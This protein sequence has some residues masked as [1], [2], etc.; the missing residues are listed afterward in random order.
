MSVVSGDGVYRESIFMVDL[1]HSCILVSRGRSMGQAMGTSPFRTV[2]AAN[3]CLWLL[4][5]GG[6][7]SIFAVRRSVYR[8]RAA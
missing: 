8:I 5:R 6:R 4:I 3:S 2:R 7:E 1:L